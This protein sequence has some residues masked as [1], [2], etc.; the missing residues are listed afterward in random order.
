MLS[1]NE[2][3]YYNGTLH[4]MLL[5]ALVVLI[6][7]FFTYIIPAGEFETITDPVT[8]I[9]SYDPD[10]FVFIA[11][12]PVKPFE[13]FKDV[14]LGLQSSSD[15]IVYLLIAGGMV[16]VLNASGAWNLAVAAILKKMKGK[17]AIIL[18]VLMLIFGIYS[19]YCATFE[20][21]LAIMPLILAI[22]IT[23][24]YD[25][26]TAIGVVYISATV[27]YAGGMTNV[28]T[29]GTAQKI[30]GLPIFS[31][32]RYRTIVFGILMLISIIYVVVKAGHV[33]KKPGIGAMYEI[34][35][36]KNYN[37][38]I[39]LENIPQVKVRHILV[40]LSFIAGIVCSVVGTIYMGFYVDELSAV[41][42][43]TMIVMGLAAGFGPSRVCKEFG[44][45]CKNMLLPGMMIGLA[46]C[47]VLILKQSHSMDSILYYMSRQ[48][49]QLPDSL[50][51]S[52]MF[53]FHL[54][55]NII[56]PSGSGQA[57]AT[58]PIMVA[59][60]DKC[61]ISRQVAVLT[62]QLGDAFTNIMIP[63]GGEIL[64]AAMI[65]HVPLSKWIRYLLPLFV[66]W[67]MAALVFIIFAV[68]NGY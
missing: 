48:L 7:S 2:K 9:E 55:F 37:R 62:Y 23:S 14:S 20:E 58:I 43:I 35:K 68:K 25:S 47:A 65:C 57:R 26:L 31:G 11:R 56:V 27:G 52:G 33:K 59:V 54:I 19:A 49:M 8:G 64:A 34:D 24:G 51:A 4:P 21:Y 6:C 10:S 13:M 41:F 36:A 12:E 18:I 50:V 53:L 66:L 60:A 3:N 63:T 30:A 39:D 44:R 22:C 5:L 61:G 1:K 42:L 29:V 28:F 40:L 17:E 32:I 38:K 45:G 15:I 16:G 67:L 46:N